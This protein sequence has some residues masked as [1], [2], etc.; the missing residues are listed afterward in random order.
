MVLMLLSIRILQPVGGRS[1]PGAKLAE[2]IQH[3]LRGWQHLK[4]A[5]AFRF[6]KPLIDGPGFTFDDV[7]LYFLDQVT[8]SAASGK[9]VD[10]FLVP[11]VMVEFVK[12]RRET[13]AF[14]F[15]QFTDRRLEIVHAHTS[16]LASF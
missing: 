1:I 3:G 11:L 8:A 14:F 5:S 4:Q 13:V 12:P 6:G 2:P 16:K 9:I 10:H 15:W 7:S